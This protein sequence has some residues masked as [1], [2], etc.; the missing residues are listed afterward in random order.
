[1]KVLVVIVFICSFSLSSAQKPTK[2][3]LHFINLFNQNSDPEVACYRIPSLITAANG[4][5]IAAI[6]ERV[7]SCG[8]LKWSKDINIVIRRSEDQ[9]KDVHFKN[10][11]PGF[12]D[13]T[14]RKEAIEA[15]LQAIDGKPVTVCD[16][17]D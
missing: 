5:L 13:K 4:D 3:S 6:D 8:D 11:Y 7:P 2:D 17:R 16:C 15:G 12:E 9:G 14:Y 1:M 10:I